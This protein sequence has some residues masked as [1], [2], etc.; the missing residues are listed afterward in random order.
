[1]NQNKSIPK[2]KLIFSDQQVSIYQ[3]DAVEGRINVY[4]YKNGELSF[5]AERIS[6][7]N[8]FEKTLAYKNICKSLTHR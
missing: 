4:Q 2:I 3:H 5:G 7:L 1:M 8:R 6:I